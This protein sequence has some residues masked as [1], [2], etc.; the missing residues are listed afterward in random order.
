[1]ADND[2]LIFLAWNDL[3]GVTRGRGVP[4]KSYPAR[5]RT[6]INWAMAGQA[7]T[8]FEDIADNPWGPMDEAHMTPA[9]ETQI[10]VDVGGG[11]PPLAMVLCDGLTT[12]GSVWDPA[13]AASARA[14]RMSSSNGPGSS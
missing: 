1:M 4:L 7:L 12:D 3:V 6:G 5:R 14:R 11:Q 2:E 10:R 8:P 13:R 9:P